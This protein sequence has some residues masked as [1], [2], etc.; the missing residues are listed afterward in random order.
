[1][2]KINQLNQFQVLVF[3]SELKIVG[4]EIQFTGP[5]SPI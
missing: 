5:H 3:D 2:K 1:M 4:M